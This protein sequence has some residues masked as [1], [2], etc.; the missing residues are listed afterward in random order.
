[1]HTGDLVPGAA[2]IYDAAETLPDEL[3]RDDVVYLPIAMS[4]LAKDIGGREIMRN[5][6]ALGSAACLL[7]FDVK[8]MESVIRDNFASKGGS[9]IDGNM[10]VL[11]RGVEEA[12]P[13][14]PDFAY[15]MPAVPDAPQRL[16]LNG[17]EA[18]AMGAL[19]GGCRF[20][21]GYPMTPGS[22]VLIWFAQ[23][24][25]QYGV[26]AKHVEDEISAINMALGAGVMGVRSLVPT[27]GGGYALMVEATGLAGIW[28]TPVVL[29]NAQRPGPATG[30][31]T[32]TEQG[33]ML[34]MLFASQGEFPRIM[35]VPGSVEELFHLGWQAFNLAEKYQTPV[36][37]LSDQNLADG[38]RT[39]EPDALDFDTVT[40]ERGQLLSDSDLDAM[41]EPYLR[42]KDTAS[43]ISPRAIPGHPNAVWVTSSNE[44]AENGAIDESPENRMSMVNK[45]TRKMAGAES[46]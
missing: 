17:T 28:E 23:H 4:Q 38:L 35:L 19:A 31:P 9:V 40:L 32:R 16:L 21:S 3:H 36:M 11:A 25:A 22:P 6:L 5:T 7:D 33:D 27:S 20:V 30:M 10:Q 14:A 8:Y 37:V 24:A 45:R 41:T 39:I 44:H 1:R 13:Y 26:V 46:E 18:F 15:K 2:V 43:G 42:Y 12:K 29:Y 34:F